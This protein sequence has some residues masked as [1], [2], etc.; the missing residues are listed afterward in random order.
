MIF[1][2]PLCKTTSSR[3]D[4]AIIDIAF[5]GNKTQKYSFCGLLWACAHGGAR[6]VGTELS[7]GSVKHMNLV[8]EIDH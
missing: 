6:F 8:E 7:N 4:R 3:L 2:P 1:I 5:V